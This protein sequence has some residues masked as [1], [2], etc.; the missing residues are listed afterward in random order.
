LKRDQ[1]A[2]WADFFS[3]LNIDLPSAPDVASGPCARCLPSV[4]IRETM[5]AKI[6]ALT[7]ARMDVAISSNAYDAGSSSEASTMHSGATLIRSGEWF[8][9]SPASRIAASASA[10]ARRRS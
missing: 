2:R 7:S 1:V 3:R 5:P 10:L 4:P 6:C 8:L 9:T